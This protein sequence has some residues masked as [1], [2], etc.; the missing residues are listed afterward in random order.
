ML[1][2]I[3]E[4]FGD[5]M[6]LCY[7]HRAEEVEHHYLDAGESTSSRIM[8]S[9]IVPLSEIVTDFFDQLKSRSSG[10]ASFE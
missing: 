10:F 3:L 7:T 6:D 5:M 8:M 4:Y 1:T 9:C 2:S